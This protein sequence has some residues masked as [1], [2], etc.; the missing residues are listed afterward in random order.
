[1]NYIKIYAELN[2]DVQRKTIFI[3]LK[4]HFWDSKHI[5]FKIQFYNGQQ[6]Q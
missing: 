5:L 6:L 4:I 2:N 3:K 1:M